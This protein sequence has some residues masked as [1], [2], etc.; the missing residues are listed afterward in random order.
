MD[1]CGPGSLAAA[2]FKLGYVP[3]GTPKGS[4]AK[5]LAKPEGLA[6]YIFSGPGVSRAWF[7]D[8]EG[9]RFKDEP[10]DSS[11]GFWYPVTEAERRA[12][13]WNSK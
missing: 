5:A 10:A 9:N 7:V 4:I 6:G 11:N 3:A 2:L 12:L 8:Q 13:G 1:S